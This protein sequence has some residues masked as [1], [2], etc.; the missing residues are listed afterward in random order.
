MD[1]L[2]I[3]PQRRKMDC[4]IAALAM[5][6][7]VP[8]EDIYVA[9]CKV[10]PTHHREGLNLREVQAIAQSFG[11]V[12]ER[13]RAYD[14]EADIGI[15]SVRGPSRTRKTDWWHYVV[16]RR[17][18]VVEPDGARIIDADDYFAVQQARPCT[19]LVRV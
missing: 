9:A 7:G 2:S 5:L 14:I 16:L 8:Y 6:L 17:G 11:T 19:L 13:R 10:A 12:L 4:G 18:D 15:L 3:V 1:S